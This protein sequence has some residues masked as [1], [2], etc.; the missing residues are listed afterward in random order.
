MINFYSDHYFHIGRAHLAGG[1]P[2][3]DYALSE[4]EEKRAFAIIADGCSSGGNTDI[5]ARMIALATAAAI[6]HRNASPEDI[7]LARK[8]VMGKASRTLH[9]AHDDM[10]ATCAY[11]HLTETGGFIHLLG[12]G[13]F[14]LKYRDGSMLM[15]RFTWNNNMPAYAAYADDAFQGFIAAHGGDLTATPLTGE[16]Y[17]YCPGLGS[18]Q[19]Q[20]FSATLQQGIE[21]ITVPLSPYQI[22]DRLEYV[23]VFSDG[24]DQVD[25]MDWKDVIIALLSFKNTAGEFAKRRMIRVIKESQETGK[26]PLDDI[27]YAVIHIARGE[28]KEDRHDTDQRLDM[29][30]S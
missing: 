18:I 22:K 6:K 17:E 7:A 9:I 11:I 12:D 30:Q 27:S 2:C 28:E 26:G 19:V 25:G 4:Y 21:G 13:A 5:G 10:L 1:K 8:I 23:A 14:A 29:G 15:R 3:Q 24:V 20:A 16:E